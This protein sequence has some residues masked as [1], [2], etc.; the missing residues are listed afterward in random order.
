MKFIGQTSN[1]NFARKRGSRDKKP[2]KKNISSKNR[3]RGAA[4]GLG[5]GAGAQI[6]RTALE[7]LGD[8]FW[9]GRRAGKSIGGSLGYSLKTNFP[10]RLKAG[11]KR[12]MP[13]IVGTALGT[14]AAGYY[15][16]RSKELGHGNSKKRKKVR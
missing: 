7:E 10:R 6:S 14:G 13:G 16:S 8:G 11:L 12:D 2:R 1:L 3:L 5:I 4:A 15:V 9:A